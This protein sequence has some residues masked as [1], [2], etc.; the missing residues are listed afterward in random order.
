MICCGDSEC[1]FT[2]EGSCPDAPGRASN[3]LGWIFQWQCHTRFAKCCI[4]DNLEEKE[5]MG[6]DKL[7][8]NSNSDDKHVEDAWENS[9]VNG[10][11][12][13]GNGKKSTISKS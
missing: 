4:R 1:I 8:D 11:M 3:G 5:P 10:F 6:S 13:G 2:S 12:E 7:L 9:E